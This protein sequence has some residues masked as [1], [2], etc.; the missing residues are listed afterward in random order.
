MKNIICIWIIV[1]SF[2]FSVIWGILALIRIKKGE[3]KIA[4]FPTIAKW[5]NFGLVIFSIVPF[6]FIITKIFSTVLL[7]QDPYDGLNSLIIFPIIALILIAGMTIFSILSWFGIGNIDKKP[8]W[9]LWERISYSAL[10]ILS[11]S[12]IAFFVLWNILGY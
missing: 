10:T 3:D 12:I 9:K 7:A 6:I 1:I 8:Y 5:S 11:Y 4:I 2:I